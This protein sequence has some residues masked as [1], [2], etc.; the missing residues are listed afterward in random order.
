MQH[1]L[2]DDIATRRGIMCVHLEPAY[3]GEFLPAPLPE[4]ERARDGSILLPLFPDMTAD[5]Q[6]A[7]VAALGRAWNNEARNEV[8]RNTRHPCR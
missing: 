5:M 3:K 4:S 2:D 7:V 6:H 1:M 8:S